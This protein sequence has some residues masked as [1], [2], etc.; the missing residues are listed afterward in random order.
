MA[1]TV[2]KTD[3]FTMTVANRIGEGA[4]VLGAIRDAGINLLAFHGC[5]MGKTARLD[6]IPENS[7]LLRKA[8]KRAGF[9]LAG[10]TTCFFIQG[11][12][13][14]GAVA[15]ILEKLAA[16]GINVTAINAGSAGEGRFAAVLWVA[17]KDVRKTAKLLGAA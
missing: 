2:R 15:E 12:D 4:R 8:A 3:H 11:E 7:A 6:I 17:P 16:G 1:D 9:R 5:A 10:K 14:P 13:R